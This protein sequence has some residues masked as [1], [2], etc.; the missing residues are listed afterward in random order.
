MVCEGNWYYFFAQNKY[1]HFISMFHFKKWLETIYTFLYFF[2][3]LF[4]RISRKQTRNNCL[5]S[6]RSNAIF[7]LPSCYV[8]GYLAIWDPIP[9]C[10]KQSK[11]LNIISF[12]SVSFHSAHSILLHNPNIALK[13]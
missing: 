12:H 1:F 4:C 5:S 11:Q 9:S 13:S 6:R 7:Q 8:S 10:F 3:L 2:S